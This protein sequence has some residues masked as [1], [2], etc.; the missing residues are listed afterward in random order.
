M[1]SGK[2]ES[3]GAGSEIFETLGFGYGGGHAS[4][5]MVALR[6]EEQGMGSGAG[7]PFGRSKGWEAD[8]VP[9]TN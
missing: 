2:G 8:D 5:P 1:Y 3:M 7:E 6:E 9:W 4:L